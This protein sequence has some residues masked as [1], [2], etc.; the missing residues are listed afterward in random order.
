MSLLRLLTT[1]ATTPLPPEVVCPPRP[2]DMP[3]REIVCEV[4]AGMHDRDWESEL[5]EVH[6]E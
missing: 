4:L 3:W 6:W 5:V 2:G 1:L